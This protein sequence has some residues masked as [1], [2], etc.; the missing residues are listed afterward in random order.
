[1][2]E[3]RQI[4]R[5]PY[6]KETSFSVSVLELKELKKFSLKGKGINIHDAGL[7]I[8]IDY[9]LE[10]GHV[11]RFN[12]GVGMKVGVVKWTMRLGNSYRIGIT[13]T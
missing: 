8:Q 3:R 6:D 7:G 13:F 2:A 9:P 1:M 12:N 10:P 5:R 11:L 4:Q